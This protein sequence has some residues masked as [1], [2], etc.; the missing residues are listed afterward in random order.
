MKAQAEDFSSTGDTIILDRAP[1]IGGTLRSCAQLSHDVPFLSLVSLNERNSSTFDFGRSAFTGAPG[2]AVSCG[3]CASNTIVLEDP[4][5]SL[6]HFAI[7]IEWGS[8]CEGPCLE[9]VDESSNGTWL[10]DRLVGKDSRVP[11]ALGDRIFVLPAARVG[12]R[13]AAGYFVAA[14]PTP[15]LAAWACGSECAAA[16]QQLGLAR[17][18]VDTVRCRL[19]AETPVHRCLTTVPCGH[20]FDLGCLVAWRLR[21]DS[22]PEC[23]EAVQQAVRNRGVDSVAETFLRMRPEASREPSTVRLLDAVER[24]PEASATLRALLGGWPAG[25]PTPC[26]ARTGAPR[27]PRQSPSQTRLPSHL[28]HFAHL[29][30]FEGIV[31]QSSAAAQQRGAGASVA[32]TVS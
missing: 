17:E 29:V 30:Q 15:A 21:S 31:A 22:C 28:K 14:V 27:P 1:E 18:L 20:N 7:R 12:Q 25:V 6:R 24:A 19:C 16:A 10:N 4:R 5:V 9:L 8:G 32:C 3:R 2:A 11:L 23:G 13:D 26:R